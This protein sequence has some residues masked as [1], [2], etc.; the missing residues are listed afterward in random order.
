M[1]STVNRIAEKISEKLFAIHKVKKE[2]EVW[3]VIGPVEQLVTG[4]GKSIEDLDSSITFQKLHAFTI[5][6][7]GGFSFDQYHQR[8]YVSSLKSSTSVDFLSITGIA[9]GRF[10]ARIVAENEDNSRILR[11]VDVEAYG[12]NFALPQIA[13]SELLHGDSLVVEIYAKTVTQISNLAWIG[14]TRSR[15]TNDG[16]RI[17][18]IRTF[19]NKNIVQENLERLTD[20]LTTKEKSLKNYLFIVYDATSE[21]EPLQVEGGINTLFIKGGNYGGG[22]N[23]SLLIALLQ[24]AH[25][26][27]PEVKIDEVILWDDDAVIEPQMFIRHDS[28]I[29]FRKQEV[30]HTGIVLSKTSPTKIQEYGAIW[31]SFFDLETGQ[32][33]TKNEKQRQQYPYL[34]R[35]NRNITNNFDRKYIGTEQEIDFGTFIYI[36]IPYNLLQKI[37]GSIPFFLRNDDVELGFRLKAAGATLT[38]N[39]NIFAWHE[40]TH[41]IIGEFYATLHGMI[42]NSAYCDLDKAWLIKSLMAKV[43]GASSVKNTALLEAYRQAIRLFLNG[44]QWMQEQDVFQEYFSVAKVIGD[45]LKR[46]YQVPREVVDTMKKQN[47]IEVHSLTNSMVSRKNAAA[48][49]VFYDAPNKRYL[50]PNTLE[51][52]TDSQLIVDLANQIGMLSNQFDLAKGKWADFIKN[53]EAVPYW[54]KFFTLSGDKIILGEI[55]PN[56]FKTPSLSFSESFWVENLSNTEQSKNNALPDDFSPT[57][58]LK[59]N[60]DVANAGIDATKHYLEFGVNEGRR[61]R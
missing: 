19:G 5:S 28:F 27:C 9:I 45:R 15:K 37:Q 31:G 47:M 12:Q 41:N 35:F 34:V 24:K 42:V 51:Q 22:G 57:N 29:S 38:V 46:Y 56:P 53:F 36:S 2:E 60:P 11:S 18:L 17:V 13:V 39:Q 14:T 23:A 1:N 58:Y 40:A 33:C 16:L 20:Y 61:Y 10:T 25:E 21:I 6:A 4:Y 49:V 8:L 26:S 54:E 59:L 52:E 48:S 50:K 43:T 32:I 3:R 7:G 30:A 55:A 44:P